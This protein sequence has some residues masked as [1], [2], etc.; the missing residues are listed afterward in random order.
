MSAIGERVRAA[1]EALEL[2]QV[3]CAAKAEMRPHTL[4][5]IEA[6]KSEPSVDALDRLARVLGVSTDHLIRGD[7]KP[8]RAA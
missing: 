2:S 6:G 7:K 5:R 8:G 1:R 3:D 4:W